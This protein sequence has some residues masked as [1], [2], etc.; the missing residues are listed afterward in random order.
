[1]IIEGYPTLSLAYFGETAEKATEVLL[2]FVLEEGAVAMEPRFSSTEDVRQDE[3]IQ[4]V[5]VK[6]IE[7]SAA[8]TVTEVAG[9]AVK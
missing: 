8:K 5:L 7:R 6:I 2:T 9:V 4:S 3:T 1:M